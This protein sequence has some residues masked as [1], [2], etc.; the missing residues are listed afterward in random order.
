MCR[1]LDFFGVVFGELCESIEIQAFTSF[2][3]SF[4]DPLLLYL[5]LLVRIELMLRSLLGSE[6]FICL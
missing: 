1:L 4:L 3:A 5:L 6:I 2:D